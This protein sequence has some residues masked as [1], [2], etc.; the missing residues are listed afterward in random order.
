[1]D[2]TPSLPQAVQQ[3]QHGYCPWRSSSSSTDDVPTATSPIN[4]TD[5][6]TGRRR[7]ACLAPARH[8]NA[9]QPGEV[10]G[11]L[12]V[13]EIPVTR[14]W[15]LGQVV[16]D[17]S[18]RPAHAARAGGSTG[19]AEEPVHL[20]RMQRHRQP[21][22]P[23]PRGDQAGPATSR[24]ADRDPPARPFLS[25]RRRR[26]SAAAPRWSERPDAPRARVPASTA[27]RTR[28]LPGRGPDQRLD[29]EHVPLPAVGP[30]NC[31]S[32]AVRWRTA[33]PAPGCKRNLEMSADLG[34]PT[35]DGPLPPED[36]Y[37]PRTN[38][39]RFRRLS[40]APNATWPHNREPATGKGSGGR[41]G[42]WRCGNRDG[43][44]GSV[45]DQGPNLLPLGRWPS[46][47]RDHGD[48]APRCPRSRSCCS[49]QPRRADAAV[50]VVEQGRTSPHLAGGPVSVGDQR[51]THRALS[52][53]QRW[54]P[55]ACAPPSA[56]VAVCRDRSRRN[57]SHVADGRSVGR[58]AGDAPSVVPAVTMLAVGRAPGKADP[59]GPLRRSLPSKGP[60]GLGCP[61][62]WRWSPGPAADRRETAQW[63]SSATRSARPGRD[64]P[65]CTGRSWKRRVALRNRPTVAP[66]NLPVD[67]RG[68]PGRA[69]G[70]GSRWVCCCRTRF[71]TVLGVPLV[72]CTSHLGVVLD[73]TEPSTAP[74]ARENAAPGA[75][76][77]SR[78]S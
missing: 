2:R 48:A 19:N 23:A 47:V 20:R 62:A 28:F 50:A 72:N 4:R 26:H 55:L 68:P 34:R 16:T 63:P 51:G 77:R 43:S 53:G 38:R 35:R 58:S 40:D 67:D 7:S 25:D 37:G 69:T 30:C 1:M 24:P 10:R 11:F 17:E 13:A 52:R 61:G 22:R 78:P 31:A 66:E 54:L 14:P 32:K 18:A 45:V 76:L 60:N 39:P 74:T 56:M 71:A 57:C 6:G 3:L 36:R 65:D 64:L 12:G 70:C 21:A 75:N 15:L 9:Q 49:P 46:L 5:A 41:A 73:E 8:R 29:Q 42:G 33:G 59:R 44:G 27:A